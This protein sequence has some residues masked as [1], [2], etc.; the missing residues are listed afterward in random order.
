MHRTIEFPDGPRPVIRMHQAPIELAPPYIAPR[1]LAR[2]GLPRLFRQPG[3][4]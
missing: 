2:R 3:F 4:P 1:A